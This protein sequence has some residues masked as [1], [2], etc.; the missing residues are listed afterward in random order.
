[1]AWEAVTCPQCGAPLPRLALWRSVTCGSCGALIKKTE[2]VV[3]RESFRQALQRARQDSAGLDAIECGGARYHLIRTLGTGTVSQVHLGR[4]VGSLPLLVTIKFSIAPTAAARYAR[5]AQVSHELQLLDRDGAGAH[6]SRLLPEVVSQSVADGSHGKNVIVLRHPTGCWGSLAA[7][8]DQCG[9]G[10]DPRH[11]VWIWR[12]MLEV[13]GF[14]LSH[15]WSHGDVRPEH[16]LVHPQDH[17]VLLIGWASARNGAG[18]DDK[19]SDICRTA[20]VVRV[21]LC[22]AIDG[23][24]PDNVPP[25]L[26]ELVT[27]AAADEDFCGAQGAA[28]LDALLQATAKAAFGPPKFVPLEI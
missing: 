18:P 27:Q 9:S 1:M 7:L 20:R 10:I 19:A 28:G 21:L 6:F 14:V 24:L 11:T 15:G 23:D 22:G 8:N 16:A 4:R 17:G 5:E 3:T 2:S 26:A 12:R 13:L 25:A